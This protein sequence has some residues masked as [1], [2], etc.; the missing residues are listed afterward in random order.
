[1]RRSFELPL[2]ALL[3]ALLPLSASCGGPAV[4]LQLRPASSVDTSSAR[5]LTINVGEGDDATR[6]PM[7]L[8]RTKQAHLPPIEIDPTVPVRLDVWICKTDVCSASDLAFRGCTP[9]PIDVSAA[10]GIV[11]VTIDIF[12]VDDPHVDDCPAL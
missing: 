1:M 5:S 8:D 3:W 4:S 12:S 6:L 7:V 2:W 11:P 9:V 10:D